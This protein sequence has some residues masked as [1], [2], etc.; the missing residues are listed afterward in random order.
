MT[1]IIYNSDQICKV[2][3]TYGDLSQS[4]IVKC[5][6]YKHYTVVLKLSAQIANKCD[7]SLK[8]EYAICII[9]FS[10]SSNFHFSIALQYTL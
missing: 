1:R 5:C 8:F 2:Y 9:L 3:F 7:C 10:I 6:T 4:K